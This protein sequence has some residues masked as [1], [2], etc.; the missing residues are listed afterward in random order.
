MS[1]KQIVNPKANT[2]D[3]APQ[4]VFPYEA[5]SAVTAKRVAFMDGTGKVSQATAAAANAKDIGIF[6]ESGAAGS[7]VP[8]CVRGRVNG[9][10][11]DGAIVDG[12]VLIRDATT[13][14]A[15]QTAAGT[16]TSQ[17]TLGFAIGASYAT[18]TKVDM[19]VNKA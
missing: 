3:G 8:V 9:V 4:T 18:N 19:Y 10:L 6:L 11:V 1:S 7:V 15:V 13:A 17:L 2:E 16:E 12:A 5:A 14:G